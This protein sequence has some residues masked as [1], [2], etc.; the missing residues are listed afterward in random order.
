MVGNAFEI[1]ANRF[2][3]LQT[4]IHLAMYKIDTIVLSCCVLHN[5]LRRHAQGYFAS[6]PDLEAERLDRNIQVEGQERLA[7]LTSLNQG[8]TL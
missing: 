5:Y 8:H 1:L 7:G 2:G 3:I 6:A 4:S